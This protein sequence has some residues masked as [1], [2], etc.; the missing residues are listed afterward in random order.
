[1]HVPIS[2]TMFT[3][4]FTYLYLWSYIH[5]WESQRL[6]IYIYMNSHIIYSLS[7]WS[8]VKF[9]EWNF[10][11]CSGLTSPNDIFMHN[12]VEKS[13]TKSWLTF[14]YT[15]LCILFKA[16]F[17]LKLWYKYHHHALSWLSV[18]AELAEHK[19]YWQHLLPCFL[20]NMESLAWQIFELETI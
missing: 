6:Y 16:D 2:N 1:M 5:A 8:L 14:K 18:W 3:C 4:I 15:F 13:I 7:M 19:S 20:Y 9:K 12:P 11:W 10:H 17:F